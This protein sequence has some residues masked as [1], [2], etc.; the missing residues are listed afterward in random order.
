M[1][2]R[3]GQ[4]EGSVYQRGDDGLWVGSLSLGIGPDGKR[5]RLTVYAQT[6]T[7]A[8]QKL[9]AAQQK[10]VE[11]GA[12]I[13]PD[14]KRVTIEQLLGMYLDEVASSRLRPKTMVLYRYI[15]TTHLIPAL[16]HAKI[17][18]LT[19]R[20]VQQTFNRLS[21]QGRPPSVIR[22]CRIL[23]R[24]AIGQAQKWE[25]VSRNV[26][27]LTD[28][29]KIPPRP[30]PEF[31]EEQ[32]SGLLAA[33]RA[34]EL[35]NLFL[36]QLALGLRI[37]E[38]MGLRVEDLQRSPSGR[39]Q[40]VYIR[41]QVQVLPGAPPT[42]V[43]PKTGMGKRRVVAPDL[44]VQAIEAELA[45]W[46]ARRSRLAK[47][48]VLERD[49]AKLAE[50]WGLIF[51]NGLG[52]PFDDRNCRRRFASLLKNAGLPP[53]RPHDLRHLCVSLLVSAGVPLDV[54]ADIVGHSNTRV[55][56]GYSHILPAAHRAA[57]KALDT[58]VGESK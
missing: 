34:H 51:R 3:R 10:A 1:G 33:L 24:S 4:G 41:V 20:Q 42:L 17:T 27:N 50:S 54:V 29:P 21:E 45:A 11:S 38:V 23:L 46:E 48:G 44:A 52:G 55:T 58:A 13:E 14:A 7:E 18:T 16:G 9:R 8:L 25:W 32:V 39:I 5:R 56:R 2:R 30:L 40:S 19:T 15:A 28:P 26:A 22:I 47:T 6:K 49:G 12:H 57:A 43:P 35:G 53:M 37:G 31:T 36:T